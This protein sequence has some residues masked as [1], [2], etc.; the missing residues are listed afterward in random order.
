MALPD[1]SSD[2]LSTMLCKDVVDKDTKDT[3]KSNKSDKKNNTNN[4]K[5]KNNNTPEGESSTKRSNTFTTASNIPTHLFFDDEE[6]YTDY[7]SYYDELLEKT[8]VK[9]DEELE[10]LKPYVEIDKEI[11]CLQDLIDL[12]NMYNPMNRYSIDLKILSQLVDPLTELN[13]MIG[14]ES[15][16][17]DMVDHILFRIQNLDNSHMDMMHTVIQGPPGVGKTE[18]AKIIGKV[19]LAMGILKN[20]KFVKASRSTLIGQYLGETAKLTQKIIN[21]AEG[22]I[23][24]IDEVYSLGNSEKRDSFSKECIDTINENLT[25]KKKDLICIIAGY[26]KEI[27]SCFFAYNAGLER[28]FP[29]RFTIENYTAQELFRIFQKKVKDETWSLENTVN[30]KFFVDNMEHF[31]YFGGDIEIL[32][33][34]CKRAHARR[35][36]A[37]KDAIKKQLNM[38]DLKRGFES[39]R[40]H[41]KV[42]EKEESDVWKTMFM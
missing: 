9:T 39:F 25:E 29:I 2:Y 7:S 12:G 28:R 31:K 26:K 14:M 20:D 13:N 1:K 5:R 38:V 34:R 11:N 23:L 15:V 18:V 35:V 4:N 16:K 42:K 33:S 6:D 21:S 36:F 40:A 19:Y 17:Q 41:R 37:S 8:V 32:F 24:F 3:N 30:D 22:G 27:D 10:A